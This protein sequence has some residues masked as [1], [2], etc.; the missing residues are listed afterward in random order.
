MLKEHAKLMKVFSDSGEIIGRKKLQKMIY[1]AKKM[2]FPFYEK[3][4]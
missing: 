1:I 2:Q 3:Y 4:D